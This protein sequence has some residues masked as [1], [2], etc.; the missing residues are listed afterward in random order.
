MRIE[1]T[2]RG[3]RRPERAHVRTKQGSECAWKGGAGDRSERAPAHTAARAPRTSP[4][5]AT[6]QKVDARAPEVATARIKDAMITS[7]SGDK[8]LPLPPFLV[9]SSLLVWVSSILV[10]DS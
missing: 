9:C 5:R 1:R 6:P 8:Y 3:A 10:L 2:A 7:S 4:P